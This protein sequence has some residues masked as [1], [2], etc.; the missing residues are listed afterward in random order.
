MDLEDALAVQRALRKKR[1]LANLGFKVLLKYERKPGWNGELPFYMFK[2]QNCKLLACDY[3][4]GFEERQYLSCPE[5][6]ERIDFVRFSTKI[7]MFFSIL[8]LLFRLRF[9]RK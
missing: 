9:S 3:P 7:K 4:H 2:C 5:C 1:F 6:G 8:S